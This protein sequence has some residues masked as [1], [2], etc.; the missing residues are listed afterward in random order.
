MRKFSTLMV[1]AAL[2]ASGCSP[3]I[4][5]IDRTQPNALSKSMFAGLWYHRATVVEADPDTP[6]ARDI[7][8]FTAV[9]EGVT[10][11]TEKIRWEM[12]EELLIAYRSY[13]F[14]PYAEG[15]TDE[16]RDFFGAPVAAFPILSH[17]D[18]Q[19][20]YN[21]TTGVETNV[22]SEN[23]TD[24]PWNERQYIRVDWSQNVV[25][26]TPFYIGFDNFPSGS[27]SGQAAVGYYVQDFDETSPDRPTF[28]EDYFDIT[29]IYSLEPS[30]YFC[31]MM[32]LF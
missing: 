19:R 32:Q 4:Q 25:R 27:L 3:D 7:F 11:N 24:R 9:Y 29:N 1:G 6:V 30:S 2:A 28:T 12:T 22:I 18:I 21:R 13:E 20:E 26:Q 15:L 16:G 5:S 8:G 10:S 23:T 17:F 31:L 14:I